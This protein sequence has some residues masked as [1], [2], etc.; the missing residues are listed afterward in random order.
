MTDKN[1]LHITGKDATYINCDIEGVKDEGLRTKMIGTR[2]FNFRKDHP[3]LWISVIV[4]LLATIV[5]GVVLLA[6][7]YGYFVE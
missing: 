6:I 7:E 3:N 5:G 1:A 2:I 4:T